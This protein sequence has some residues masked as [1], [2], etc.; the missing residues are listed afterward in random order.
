[1]PS[2]A[3]PR[4]RDGGPPRGRS[5]HPRSGRAPRAPPRAGT[6]AARARAVGRRR[7][8]PRRR[9]SA[10]VELAA[11]RA[12]EGQR[13]ERIRRARLRHRRLR[14]LER[15]REVAAGERE[16][17]RQR[18]AS[19]AIPRLSGV[20][21]PSDLEGG[22]PPSLVLENVGADQQQLR[23]RPGTPAT[24]PS[25]AARRDRAGPRFARRGRG[26]LPPGASAPDAAAD[27]RARRAP[28][29]DGR[30]RS[31]RRRGARDPRGRSGQGRVARS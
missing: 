14:Q 22:R 5:R 18:E 3:D 7:A 8:L 28:A 26:G 2:R 16:A 24:S 20:R 15:E 1:M 27:R 9:A 17:P 21:L 30:S 25:G 23:G 19:G 10:S 29:R 31:R 11:S 13:L 12:D 4:R 6:S